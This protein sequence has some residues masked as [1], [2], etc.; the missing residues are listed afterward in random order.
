ME[1]VHL[2]KHVIFTIYSFIES[3][4]TPG[5]SINLPITWHRVKHN[6][7]STNTL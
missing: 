6:F 4:L 5:L 1:I 3:L 7:F 2:V